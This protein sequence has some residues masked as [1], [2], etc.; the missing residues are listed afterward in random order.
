M[1]MKIGEFAEYCGLSIRALRLYDRMDLLKPADIDPDTGYR[2]YNPEQIQIV[3]A[4][5]SYKKVGF[6]LREIKTLLS[7]TATRAAL[8]RK[9]REKMKQNDKKADILRYHNQTIQSILTTYQASMPPDSEQEAAE[10]LFR[11]VC[12]ENNSLEHMFSKILWL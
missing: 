8:I 3:D 6:T 1:K 7:P 9:L 11:I 4:I 12:L 5:K 10:R 2:S